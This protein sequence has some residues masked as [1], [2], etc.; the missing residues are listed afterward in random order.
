MID[1]FCITCYFTNWC[2][3][4]INTNIRRLSR[5]DWL[6]VDCP[7]EVIVSFS[8]DWCPLHFRAQ[9]TSSQKKIHLTSFKKPETQVQVVVALMEGA[10]AV[11]RRLVPGICVDAWLPEFCEC[12]QFPYLLSVQTSWCFPLYSFNSRPDGCRARDKI[13]GVTYPLLCLL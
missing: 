11:R 3:V 5:T 10:M 13:Q 7:K 12:G 6:I 8:L 4:S 1:I 2:E 9:K